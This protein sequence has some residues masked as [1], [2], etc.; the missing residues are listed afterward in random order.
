[1]YCLDEGIDVPEFQGAIL[2][3]SASSMRQYIQRRGRILRGAVK[4][5]IA[6][7]YDIIVI[8][9]AQQIEN[10]EDI[11]MTIVK[12]E[13]QRVEELSEDSLNSSECKNKINAKFSELGINYTF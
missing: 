10:I 2:V 6:E 3:S 7:L 9:T 8:P 12:K 5:K 4:G 11:A 13:L 1:M